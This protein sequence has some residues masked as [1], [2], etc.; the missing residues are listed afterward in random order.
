MDAVVS[1]LLFNACLVG[2]TILHILCLNREG[3]IRQMAWKSIAVSL[4]WSTCVNFYAYHHYITR[5]NVDAG[6]LT[7]W[8]EE[9]RLSNDSLY[10]F[11]ASVGELWSFLFSLA[12]FTLA[13][14]LNTSY[15]HWK[16][17]YFAARAMQ[18]SIQVWQICPP[19]DAF[20]SHSLPRPHRE[21][22]TIYACW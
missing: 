12:V 22:L 2:S 8:A 19:L 20:D 15:E 18:V 10:V 16:A 7:W 3:T 9:I 14:F 11:L 5:V 17:V 21:G 1:V 4:I 6:P 13:F